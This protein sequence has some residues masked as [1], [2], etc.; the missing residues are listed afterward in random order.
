M[1]FQTGFLVAL[2]LALP[3]WAH[4]GVDHGEAVASSDVNDVAPRAVARSEAFELVAVLASDKLTVYLDRY[5]DNTPVAGAGIEIESGA[6][7]TVAQPIAP[8]VYEAPAAALARPGHYPLTVSIETA[9]SADLLSATL[10]VAEPDAAHPVRNGLVWSGI[11]A[12]AVWLLA[13]IGFVL[14]R[15]GKPAR[16]G[17]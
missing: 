12:G 1:K 8:G 16:M 13:G 14:R 15:R 9:D 4:D 3:A 10:E 17:R 5:A 6:F 11:A 7:K 2:L